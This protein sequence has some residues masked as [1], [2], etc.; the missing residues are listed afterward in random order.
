MSK[1]IRK[2]VVHLATFAIGKNVDAARAL[3]W[4]RCV[5]FLEKE[6]IG[7]T[8][9]RNLEADL[10]RS[11]NKKSQNVGDSVVTLSTLEDLRAVWRDIFQAV[12]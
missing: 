4:G 10:E 8:E 7:D 2:G 12:D 3:G 11:S 9:G 1:P 6:P 5:H